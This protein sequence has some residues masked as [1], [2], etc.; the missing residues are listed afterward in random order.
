MTPVTKPAAGSSPLALDLSII[1]QM[2]AKLVPGREI[3]DFSLSL[4]D[5]RALPDWLELSEDRILR[6]SNEAFLSETL[7]MDLVYSCG[8]VGRFE[9]SADTSASP[10]KLRLK[11][12]ERAGATPIFTAQLLSEEPV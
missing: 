11:Q 6:I 3:T 1:L 5:G 2:T 9:L 4:S 7:R 12:V 10:A 8:E